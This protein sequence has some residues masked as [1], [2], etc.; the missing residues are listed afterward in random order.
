MSVAPRQR[1]IKSPSIQDPMLINS[2]DNHAS[3][4]NLLPNPGP[5]AKTK[6]SVFL[7]LRGLDAL[8]SDLAKRRAVRNTYKFV[9]EYLK[10]ARPKKPNRDK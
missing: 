6:M 3:T 1:R 5:Q 9:S 10:L 7:K 2:L 4:L 8:A